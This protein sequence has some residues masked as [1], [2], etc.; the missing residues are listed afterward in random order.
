MNDYLITFLRAL[1]EHCP[2]PLGQV[3]AITVARHFDDGE[4]LHADRLAVLVAREIKP[5]TIFIEQGDFTTPA[6]DL[7]RQCADL[8]ATIEK[9]PE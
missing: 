4:G 5:V 9:A 7:A 2:L 8:V 6:R 3:H 1:E